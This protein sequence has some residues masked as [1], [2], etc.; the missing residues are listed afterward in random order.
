MANVL[1]AHGRVPR[2]KVEVRELE[3]PECHAPG[4][5]LSTVGA[6]APRPRASSEWSR[7]LGKSR[8]SA[9]WHDWTGSALSG[10]GLLVFPS[11]PGARAPGCAYPLRAALGIFTGHRRLTGPYG[12]GVGQLEGASRRRLPVGLGDHSGIWSLQ[13]SDPVSIL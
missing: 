12:G 2:D 13:R 11:A 7:W 6:G 4:F 10:S 1:G 8:C 5:A 3:G 9:G